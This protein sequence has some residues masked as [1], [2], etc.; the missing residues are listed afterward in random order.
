MLSSEFIEELVQPPG[1]EAL[2][3]P[4]DEGESPRPG[5]ATVGVAVADRERRALCL[6]HANL[7]CGGPPWAYAAETSIAP[8]VN[9]RKHRSGCYHL[10]A[11]N[12]P[13][14]PVRAR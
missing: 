6:R 11:M 3:D 13:V 12:S 1:L 2:A 4:L 9:T 8:G 14:T 10:P 7:F 5:L